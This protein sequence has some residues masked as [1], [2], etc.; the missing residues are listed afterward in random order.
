[1]CL[2]NVPHAE[3]AENNIWTPQVVTCS[4]FRASGI[5]FG[6][7]LACSCMRCLPCFD[8][9][10]TF[11]SLQCS[12]QLKLFNLV[13]GEKNM[14]QSVFIRFYGMTSGPHAMPLLLHMAPACTPIPLN[15]PTWGTGITALLFT[16]AHYHHCL[17]AAHP[18]ITAI[19]AIT[20]G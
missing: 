10:F 3:L 5:L 6:Y 7:W 4:G 17:F 12:H 20:S 11:L 13:R 18:A 8:P 9:S 16:P 2:L 19:T 1:M 14:V 15:L